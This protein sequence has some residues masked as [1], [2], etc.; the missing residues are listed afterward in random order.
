ME[1]TGEE[2]KLIQC[3][4]KFLFPKLLSMFQASANIYDKGSNDWPYKYA[5]MHTLYM[6]I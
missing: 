5:N 1:N 4:H 3:Y 2:E 6:Y